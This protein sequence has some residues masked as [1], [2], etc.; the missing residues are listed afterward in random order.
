MSNWT[1]G[2]LAAALV[3]GATAVGLAHMKMEKSLPAADST[4]TSKPAKVQLWFTQAP[5]KAVSRI[6]LSGPSGEVKLG[7]VEVG[8]DKSISAAVQGATPDGAY[9]VAWQAAGDDG[10]V[11]KG[12][13]AFTVRQTR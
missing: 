6:T 9:K 5:D 1:R 3:V 10:H 11:Q 8:A 12:E 4:I 2:W 7:P 13:Y